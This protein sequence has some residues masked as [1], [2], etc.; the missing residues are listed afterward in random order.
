MR[1]LAEQ[2]LVHQPGAGWRYGWSHTVL[3][4]V[5][6]VAADMPLDEYLA[7]AIFNPLEMVDTGF[8]VPPDKVERLAAVY[9]PVGGGAAPDRQR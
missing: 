3:G 7:A 4:R 1:R 9:E 2:P 6:E 8:H 5:I